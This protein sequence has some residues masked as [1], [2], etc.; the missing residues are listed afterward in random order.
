MWSRPDRVA[1]MV[2]GA[3]A[4]S[5]VPADAQSSWTAPRTPEGYPDL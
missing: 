3:L 4:L 5:S 2:V 1:M